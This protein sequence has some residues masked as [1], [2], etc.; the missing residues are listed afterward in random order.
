MP[1]LARWVVPATCLLQS[2]SRKLPSRKLPVPVA[3]VAA[4][5]SDLHTFG[6]VTTPAQTF[7][8]SETM[9]PHRGLTD[10]LTRLRSIVIFSRSDPPPPPSV[11]APPQPCKP[12][13]RIR[14]PTPE[15]NSVP[16]RKFRLPWGRFANPEFGVVTAPRGHAR[17]APRSFFL[18]FLGVASSLSESLHRS[19]RGNAARDEVYAGAA[20]LRA[21]PRGQ[22]RG[23]FGWARCAVR[24]LVATRGA[25]SLRL[26]HLIMRPSQRQPSSFLAPIRTSLGPNLRLASGL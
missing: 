23:G 8:K 25:M 6:I 16:R 13:R 17:V 7:K 21:R 26:R 10:C 3:V 24:S 22:W 14:T 2:R 9:R 12:I 19:F 4:T 20:C 18:L 1:Q 5:D 15:A 11:L